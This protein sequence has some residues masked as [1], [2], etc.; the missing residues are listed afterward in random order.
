MKHLTH[1]LEYQ[2]KDLLDI[3]L[4]LLQIL[5]KIIFC[6]KDKYLLKLLHLH[7]QETT[8][9]SIKIGQVGQVLEILHTTQTSEVMTSLIKQITLFLNKDIKSELK[10]AGI[11]AELQKIEYYKIA[12]YDT[13]LS[14]AKELKLTSITS[15]LNDT[16]NQVY[17]IN[18]S[19]TDLAE[20]HMNKKA[21]NKY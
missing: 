12:C 19:L 20:N 8:I 7:L 11:I 10:D 14:Y 5:P 13:T 1:L 9:Q 15:L 17:E 4:Q 3:E 16:L 18:E 2:V 6:A 21:A